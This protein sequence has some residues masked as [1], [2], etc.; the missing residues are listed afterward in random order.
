MKLKTIGKMAAVLTLCASAL[1]AALLA[2][3]LQAYMLAC[4]SAASGDYTVG[5]CVVSIVKSGTQVSVKN[6]GTV[7]CYVRAAV[8]VTG[9]END[10][11]VRFS[12]LPGNGWTAQY[13]SGTGGLNGY[14]YY[15]AAVQPGA[16]TGALFSAASADGAAISNVCVYAEGIQSGNTGNYAGAW[17]E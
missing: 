17:T 7:A 8:C 11:K 3:G 13:V 10:G 15:T 16:S 12:G 9:A 2:E 1:P 14:Y 5:K 4:P 6:T